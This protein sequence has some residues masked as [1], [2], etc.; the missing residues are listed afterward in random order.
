MH[1]VWISITYFGSAKTAPAMLCKNTVD[2]WY[3]SDID[4]GCVNSE[5]LRCLSDEEVTRAGTYAFEQH[6]KRYIKVRRA[7]RDLLGR[8]TGCRPDD[9][10]IVYNSYG[11]PH[12]EAPIEFNVSYSHRMGVI[13]LAVDTML[14]ADIEQVRLIPEAGDIVR[15][16]FSDAERQAYFNL[17]DADRNGAFFEIWTRKEAFIKA[18]GRG[19]SF[20]LNE[21]SVGIDGTTG[22]VTQGDSC[23]DADWTIQDV[24]PNCNY[25]AALACKR[26]DVRIS[27]YWYDGQR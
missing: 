18:I 23:S 15:S 6:R 13:A 26:R 11:K 4:S 12:I 8:Y 10:D 3:L 2:I 24:S 21:F 1:K 22:V 27:R 20:P 14:G 5:T 17:P 19:L 25:K 7:L 9:V 16:Q